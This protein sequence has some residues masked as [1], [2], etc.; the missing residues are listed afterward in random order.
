MTEWPHSSL[1][2]DRWIDV[3]GQ[4]VMDR[5]RV[6][7]ILVAVS[8]I[9]FCLYVVGGPSP[10]KMSSPGQVDSA[11][12]SFEQN[13]EKCHVAAESGFTHLVQIALQA[14]VVI[15]DSRRCLACHPNIGTNPFSPHSRR[16]AELLA[17]KHQQSQS[18]SATT[19]TIDSVFACS[20]CH[21]EHG[22]RMTPC[23]ARGTAMAD[24]IEA[25][26]GCSSW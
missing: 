14:D 13:C 22:G 19:A 3:P 9:A 26:A 11:H 4:S 6:T 5:R 1:G 2:K 15:E 17:L 23:P 8:C 10:S 7:G 24:N 25:A 18:T 20:V 16:P 21:H 12:S